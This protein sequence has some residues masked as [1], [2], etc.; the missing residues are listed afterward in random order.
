MLGQVW[1]HKPM[2]SIYFS[3]AAVYY[4][5]LRTLEKLLT[6]SYCS[7]VL[8][9]FSVSN[10]IFKILVLTW[11]TWLSWSAER[12]QKQLS[13]QTSAGSKKGRSSKRE[14]RGGDITPR[15]RAAHTFSQAAK[16]FLF[17]KSEERSLNVVLW[18]VTQWL[19]TTHKRESKCLSW[20]GY[21]QEIQMHLGKHL[22]FV[23]GV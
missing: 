21:V 23:K 10:K 14:E 22:R 5:I 16:W 11:L 17:P 18:G 9:Q 15:A 7:P 8:A 4:K 13:W 6:W 12:F 2:P 1:G 19:S 20:V 3:C